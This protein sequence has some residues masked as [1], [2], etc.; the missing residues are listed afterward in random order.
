MQKRHNNTDDRNTDGR[1]RRPKRPPRDPKSLSFPGSSLSCLIGK[2]TEGS[3]TFCLV[4]IDRSLFYIVVDQ[5]FAQ[6][7]KLGMPCCFVIVPCHEPTP[8]A[9]RASGFADLTGWC[10][11]SIVPHPREP[12]YHTRMASL[13]VHHNNWSRAIS[14]MGHLRP[15]RRTVADSRSAFNSERTDQGDQHISPAVPMSSYIRHPSPSAGGGRSVPRAARAVGGQRCA[16]TSASDRL[17]GCS[18][19]EPS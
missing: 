10:A 16:A 5:Q 3:L 2:P 8:A 17:R 6:P 4:V 7:L 12:P 15:S 14:A 19:S 9:A 18:R 1:N 13:V 11:A